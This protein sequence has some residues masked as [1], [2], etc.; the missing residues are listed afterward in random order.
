MSDKHGEPV[1]AL[2]NEMIARVMERHNISQ[3]QLAYEAQISTSHISGIIS[4]VRVLGPEVIRALWRMTEDREIIAT[5]TGDNDLCILKPAPNTASDEQISALTVRGC[6]R[7]LQDYGTS[8]R[9][10][11]D[12]MNRVKEIDHAISALSDYRARL[13]HRAQ[14]NTSR[15]V[16][17]YRSAVHPA[18]TLDSVA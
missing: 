7:V 3:K 6:S 1:M 2:H 15:A 10:H 18:R 17:A 11:D 8:P 13:T 12:A 5:L 4:G 16:N 9:D 14:T